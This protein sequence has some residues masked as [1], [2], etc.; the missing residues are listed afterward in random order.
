ME[1]LDLLKRIEDLHPSKSEWLGFY[2]DNGATKVLL[3]K[4][5]KSKNAN[6]LNFA[7]NGLFYLNQ[8]S[9]RESNKKSSIKF[10]QGEVSVDSD[11]S[12]IILCYVADILTSLY[13]D[14]LP[15]NFFQYE[16]SSSNEARIKGRID[17][18][19]SAVLNGGLS[20]KH[21]CTFKKIDFSHPLIFFSKFCFK[22]FLAIFQS[23]P[24]LPSSSV[25]DLSQMTTII[26][27]KFSE[28][29]SDLDIIKVSLDIISGVYDQ[30]PQ[31]SNI[32]PE[33]KLLA[34]IYLD[35]TYFFST[36]AGPNIRNLPMGIA[37]NLNR[38]FEAILRNSVEAFLISKSEFSD[39][40][41]KIRHNRTSDFPKF[42]KEKKEYFQMK[43]DC[44]FEVGKKT[45][46]IDAK[47]KI[48]T[49]TSEDGLDFEKIDR[50]DLY[51]ITS[52]AYTHGSNE[53]EGIYGILALHE[54]SDF[55]EFENYIKSSY[56]IHIQDKEIIV[57]STKLNKFLF[58]V[59][60]SLKEMNTAN[61]D[62]TYHQA[63]D[64]LF[65][66]LGSEINRILKFVK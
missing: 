53:V 22:H 29:R 24:L 63:A 35:S 48:A 21:H 55:D 57:M 45:V 47:H 56:S 40:K 31:F 38:A 11:S 26:D 51:Q 34:N 60:V 59:G 66:K 14:L 50:N 2:N 64:G 27:Q 49:R 12:L 16:T 61:W 19:K 3:P 7:V 18:L 44:W 20:H 62:S 39:I 42:Y 58:D 46:I 52:Y 13:E 37:L 6:D 41:F 25:D 65:I 9:K 5:L 4:S 33:C 43:P 1:A 30:H 32:I 8:L 36:Q 28:C 10:I 54:E 15:K 17:F 23:V